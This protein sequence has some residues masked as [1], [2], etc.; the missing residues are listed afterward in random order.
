MCE[1]PLSAELDEDLAACNEATQV[2]ADKTAL[3][4]LTA[5]L[6][7]GKQTRALELVPQLHQ[8]KS[9]EGETLQQHY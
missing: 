1:T 3:R 9:V 8:I 7:V 5:Y 4:L 6:K 2:E